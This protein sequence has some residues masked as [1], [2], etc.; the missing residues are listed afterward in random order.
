MEPAD[1]A[2]GAMV[3]GEV[4]ATFD[5][6]DD[7]YLQIGPEMSAQ[8]RGVAVWAILKEIGADGVQDRVSRH[9]SFAQRVSSWH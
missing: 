9:C 3:R 6:L 8:S 4:N 2:E 5:S 1:Y 7:D